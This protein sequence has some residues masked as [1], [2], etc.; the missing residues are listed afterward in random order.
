[1]RNKTVFYQMLV[2]PYVGGGAKLAMEIH[3]YAVTSRGPVS[4]LLIPKGGAAERTACKEGL[5]FMNYNVNHLVSSRWLWSCLE[6]LYLCARTARSSRG[7]IHVHSPFVYG[8]ARTFF[9]VSKLKTAVHIHLDFTEDQVRWALRLHPDLIF[10]CAD[11]MRPTVEKTLAEQEGKQS[12]IRVI[13]NAVDTERFFPSDRAAA[14]AKVG[15]LQDMPLLMMIANLS[16]HKGQETAIR[17]VAS[18]KAQGH[19]CR[20]LLVGNERASG[21]KH[22]EYLKSLSVALC[23]EESVHFVGFRNDIPELLRAADFLLLPSV[24]EGLPL[25]IL[26]AQASEAIVLAAPT[27]GIPE[28]VKDGRTGYLIAA[29]DYQG[30]AARIAGLLSNPEEGKSIA[31]SAHNYVCR[32][33]DMKRYCESILNEYDQVVGECN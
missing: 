12:R 21:Q 10:V 3:K 15:V 16:P 26:E 33:H 17:A 6:N 11:F 22:F 1:V 4:Q 7:V 31:K 2:S 18:L 25:V 24:S 29:E 28:I 8:A 9:L 23:V 13:L 27:A 5:S 14:K 20:L 32:N 19:E 30:Y